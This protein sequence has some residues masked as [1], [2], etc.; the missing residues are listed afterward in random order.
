MLHYL[1]AFVSTQ[2]VPNEK[3]LLIFLSGCIHHC[4]NCHYPELRKIDYGT[5]LVENFQDLVTVYFHR[6]TC[7]C[8]LGEGAS[9]QTTRDEFKK[10]CSYA[11]KIGLKTCLYVGRNCEIETWMHCF[12]Y[13]KLGSYDET[14][15]P[16][17]SVNTNQRF[18]QKIK[19]RIYE[20]RTADFWK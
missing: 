12:D 17:T 5:N 1:E 8:F 13:I 16:L 3:S 14:R 20:D 18:Y 7:I 11:S 10:L 6:I 9:C 19:D 15:G 2:E 4:H